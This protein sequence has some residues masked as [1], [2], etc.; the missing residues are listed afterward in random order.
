MSMKQ[1]YLDGFKWAYLMS[2]REI[3]RAEKTHPLPNGGMV[4]LAVGSDKTD[5]SLTSRIRE[6]TDNLYLHKP[7]FLAQLQ[8]FRGVYKTSSRNYFNK[9]Y[10]RKLAILARNAE[11]GIRIKSSDGTIETSAHIKGN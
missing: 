11:Q 9:L 7:H 6:L 3:Y 1:S 8:F 10:E 4:R 2:R 5:E